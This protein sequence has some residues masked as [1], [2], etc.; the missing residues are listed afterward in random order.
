MFRHVMLMAYHVL[1]PLRA[2]YNVLRISSRMRNADSPLY[3][4][5]ADA[6][7]WQS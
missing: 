5:C 1:L 3:V 7:Q 4:L 6:F 2:S